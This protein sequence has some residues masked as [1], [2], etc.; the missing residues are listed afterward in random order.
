LD[1]DLTV[2]NSTAEHSRNWFSIV[3]P[4]KRVGFA[5]QHTIGLIWD[6]DL[7]TSFNSV[8]EQKKKLF[9]LTTTQAHL[10]QVLSKKTIGLIL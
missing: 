7:I 10:I 6:N 8:A 1:N 5:E 2:L 9:F 4:P 3:F